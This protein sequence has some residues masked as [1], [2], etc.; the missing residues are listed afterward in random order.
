MPAALTEFQPS[1]SGRSPGTRRKLGEPKAARVHSLPERL[2][3]PLR[4]SELPS[5]HP[6][7]AT[8]S[9]PH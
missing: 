8:R 2:G 1:P 3:R 5:Q 6:K 7:A 4:K 9:T